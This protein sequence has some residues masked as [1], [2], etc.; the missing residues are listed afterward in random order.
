MSLLQLEF[1]LGHRSGRPPLSHG[2]DNEHLDG[3]DVFVV[4]QPDTE[5]EIE[6]KDV[7]TRFMRRSGLTAAL[8]PPHVSIQALGRYCDIFPTALAEIIEALMTVQFEP[9]TVTFDQVMSFDRNGEKPPFV[10]CSS[11]RAGPLFDLH[12]QVC[13][14]R[15][16]P[17]TDLGAVPAFT[18]HM[19]LF[20]GRKV[21]PRESLAV[22]VSWLVRQFLI[23]RSHHGER[24]HEVLWRWPPLE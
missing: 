11:R 18:P 23:V 14:A 20:Y 2:N 4:L 19:T 5:A 9:F 16:Q 21:I 17:G 24:R 15:A 8:R 10:L 22:S 12:R 1:D 13:E 7:A 3:N 6:A